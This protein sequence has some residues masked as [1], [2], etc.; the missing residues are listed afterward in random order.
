M[1]SKLNAFSFLLALLFFTTFT[2]C[3]EDNNIFQVDY[4]NAEENLLDT[5]GTVPTV[6]ES[7]LII[8]ELEVGTG[9]F[10]VISRDNILIYYTFRL[11]ET[12]QVFE[13]SY[14]NGSTLPTRFTTIGNSSTNKGEGFVEGILG[15]KEGG[16]RVLVIPPNLSVY[17]DT[18]IVDV[19]L[20]SILN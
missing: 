10:E 7:G 2:S 18:V 4:S 19:E 15:M 16:V 12:D 20:D 5:A 1:F 13:S 17:R 9:P 14:V 11:K 3:D 8:Y 6:T